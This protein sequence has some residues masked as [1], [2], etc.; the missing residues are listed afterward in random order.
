MGFICEELHTCD[1]KLYSCILGYR[2]VGVVYLYCV[3]IECIYLSG[4][5]CVYSMESFH[6]GAILYI[7]H[8]VDPQGC[9]SCFHRE[10]DCG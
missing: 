2:V 3:L 9:I 10:N 7:R 4:W 5:S 8:T 1:G 6:T